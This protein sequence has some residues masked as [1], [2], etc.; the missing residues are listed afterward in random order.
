[1]EIMQNK[2]RKIVVFT[3]LFSMMWI[4]TGCGKY[5][6]EYECVW[7][8]DSPYIYMPASSHKVVIEINGEKKDV[9]AAWAN[10]GRGITFYSD[11]INDKA[12]D[13]SIIWDAECEIKKGKLY[14][15]IIK[16]NVSDMEG[17]T[18]ILEQQPLEDD[19]SEGQS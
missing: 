1:M 11:Y 18:I 19:G 16:D 17:K 15:T 10:N 7:V 14:V 9:N 8:S 2:I 6:W 12:I 3:I 13:E 5:F 4:M